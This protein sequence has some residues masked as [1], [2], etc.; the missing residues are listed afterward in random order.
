MGEKLAILAQGLVELGASSEQ[1]RWFVDA[2]PVPER[3]LAVRAGLG[4]IGKNTMLINSDLGSF[5]FIGTVFTDLNIEV[6]GP[7]DAERC[8]SCRRCLDACPTAAFTEA[9]WLDSRRCISYLTIE[10]RGD[11]A[12]GQ[13]ELIGEWLFGCDLCQEVCPWNRKFAAKTDEMR[14]FP[15]QEMVHPSLSQL[16]QIDE[17]AFERSY[18]GTALARAGA[19]GLRRNAGQIMANKRLP[20]K[21]TLVQENG[22]GD[23]EAQ[24]SMVVKE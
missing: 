11:F 21:G 15:R 22:P 6:D 3:E 8:G 23:T 12:P 10:H 16:C 17:P 14:F 19:T 2:G 24:R 5:T 18:R 20:R 1:T 4:W 9:R 13:G 7:F